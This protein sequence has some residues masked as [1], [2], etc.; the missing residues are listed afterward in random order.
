MLDFIVVGRY[1]TIEE[2]GNAFIVNIDDDNVAGEKRS[3]VNDRIIETKVVK[4]RQEVGSVLLVLLVLL[5]YE[6][7]VRLI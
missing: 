3:A 1:Y 4:I 2:I 7:E 6:K 5:R